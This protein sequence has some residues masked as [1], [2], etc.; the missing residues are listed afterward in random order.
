MTM[1][2]V[3]RQLRDPVPAQGGIGFVGCDVPIDLFRATGRPF[4]HLPWRTSGATPWADRWLESSFPYWS[5]SILDQWHDGDFDRLE[6]VVFSRADDASQRLYY[7]V[8]ELQRRGQLRGPRPHIFDIAFVDRE[9]S[10]AHTMAAVVKLAKAFGVG[11][12]ALV[13]GIE[14]TN[15]LRGKLSTIDEQRTDRGPLYERFGRAALWSDAE[16]WIDEIV[17]PAPDRERK[18]RVVLAGSTPP[19]DRLHQAVEAAGGAVISETHVHHLGR[20]GPEVQWGSRSPARA[21]AEHLVRAS[22]GPRAM[23]D[24]SRW[25]LDR[26]RSVRA[27]AVVIWLTRE[28]E[29]LAWHLPGQQRTLDDAG[30]PTLG[31]PASRWRTDD[32]AGERIVDFVREIRAAT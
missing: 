9:S 10:R 18:P 25:I 12:D 1:E 3:E 20:L 2:M 14:R 32:G 7:Y 13:E 22:V 4:G 16:S 23:I 21:I 5:R 28:D 6:A 31:L 30:V 24:R 29:A 17:L 11:E 15:A 26:S 19:D 27:D 8:T